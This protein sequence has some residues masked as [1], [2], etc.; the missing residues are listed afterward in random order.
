[1]LFRKHSL[2]LSLYQL[3]AV[4]RERC[5][6]GMKIID[7]SIIFEEDNLG[8]DDSSMNYRVVLFKS[9]G[10]VGSVNNAVYY[11]VI[12]VKGYVTVSGI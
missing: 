8:T 11:C 6:R 4:D 5:N 7:F 9:D 1:M 10:S 2:K 12:L 3:V